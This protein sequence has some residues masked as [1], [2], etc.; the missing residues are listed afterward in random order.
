MNT[1][2]RFD[3]LERAKIPSHIPLV[4]GTNGANTDITSKI[5]SFKVRQN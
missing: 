3:S 5:Q 1:S 2:Q 4:K